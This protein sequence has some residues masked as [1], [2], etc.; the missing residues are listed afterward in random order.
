MIVV[1]SSAIIAI[2]RLEPESDVF[3]KA[4]VAADAVEMSAVSA[5]EASMV[6]AGARG[7]VSAWAPFDELMERAAI[8]VV[9]FD[10][11]QHALARDAFLRFGKGRHPAGLNLGDCASHALATLRGARILFKGDDFTKTDL[12]PAVPA[13]FPM[14]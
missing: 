10:H 9:P 12:H 7:G 13:A 6:L 2:L 5:L 3:L 8:V 1:D 11:Q 14:H 4:I